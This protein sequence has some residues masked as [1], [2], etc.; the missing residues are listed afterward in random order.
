MLIIYW[1]KDR[2]KKFGSINAYKIQC[3]GKR[4]VGRD[5]VFGHCYIDEFL[6]NPDNVLLD[7]E[8]LGD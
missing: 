8:W 1:Y 6:S 3:M 5:C 2:H 4:D 7:E